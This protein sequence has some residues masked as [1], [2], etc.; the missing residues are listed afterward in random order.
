MVNNVFHREFLLGGAFR[1]TGGFVKGLEPV[2]PDRY[3]RGIMTESSACTS[4]PVCAP[5]SRYERNRPLAL[6]LFVERGF[7]QVSLREVA[8]TLELTV[9]TFYHHCD[10]KQTLLFEFIEEHYLRLLDLFKQRSQGRR[11]TSITLATVL[12]RLMQLYEGDPHYFLL[13]LRE[14]HTLRDHDHLRI[15]A[16]RGQ[17][18][19]HLTQLLLADANV[20]GKRVMVE[21]AIALF[22]QLPLWAQHCP[23]IPHCHLQ[24]GQRLLA[25]TL[26]TL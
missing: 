4:L 1:F 6:A 8:A 3:G 9:G 15:D 24:L 22:E 2:K 23:P 17:L 25:A 10:C 26:H 13:A 18:G 20:D 5:L 16:L 7:G 11:S 21:P 19:G 14:R 12:E